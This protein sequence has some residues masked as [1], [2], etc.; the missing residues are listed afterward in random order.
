M[1]NNYKESNFNIVLFKPQIPPNTGNIIRLCSN[2]G[3]SLHLIKPLGF[4]IDDKALRRAGLDYHKNVIINEYE[5]IDDCLNKLKIRDVFFI[6][7]FGTEKY[8]DSTYKVGDTLIFGS[9]IDGIPQKVM[10]KY[11]SYKKLFI[12]MKFDNRSLN[13]SNAVSICL[14]EAWKQNNF[15]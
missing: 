13:L 9:E 10:N 12:P 6:T 7:K 2:T 5:S 4:N 14:Y 15:I 3:S 11:K 8:S 1:N